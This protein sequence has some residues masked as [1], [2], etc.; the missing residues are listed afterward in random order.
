MN[1]KHKIVRSYITSGD[2]NLIQLLMTAN[3]IKHPRLDESA[4]SVVQ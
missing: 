4:I 2:E 1:N 3:F